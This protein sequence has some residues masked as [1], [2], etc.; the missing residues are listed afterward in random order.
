MKNNKTIIITGALGQDGLILSQILLNKGYNVIGILNKN[1][2]HKIK[3]VKYKK[4][5]FPNTMK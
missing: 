1:R 4:L 3:K 5:I 2:Q